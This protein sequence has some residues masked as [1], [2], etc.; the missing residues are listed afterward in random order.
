MKKEMR[1]F[2]AVARI[3][4]NFPKGEE[5]APVMAQLWWPSVAATMDAP[6]MFGGDPGFEGDAARKGCFIIQY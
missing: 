2:V 4:P 3:A 5:F 6:S 1:T